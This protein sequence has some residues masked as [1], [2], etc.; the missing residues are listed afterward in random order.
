MKRLVVLFAL[1]ST[2]YV[3][4]Q[5]TPIE[6]PKIVIK[7]P[8]NEA[9]Q[10]NVVSITFLEVIED[11]RCPKELTCIWAGRAKVR[12]EIQEKDK[13]S[14]QKEIIIG[15]LLEGETSDSIL[16]STKSHTVRVIDLYPLPASEAVKGQRIYELLVHIEKK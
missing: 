14:Y 2:S 13:K 15:E 4:S 12:I 6:P 8:I 11:S 9:L 3:F 16:F 5:K 7:L 1:I 10:L